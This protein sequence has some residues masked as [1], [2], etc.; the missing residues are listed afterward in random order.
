MCRLNKNWSA[1]CTFCFYSFQGIG[2]FSKLYIDNTG[3]QK[4]LTVGEWSIWSAY[5]HQS[6]SIMIQST[7]Q[8]DWEYVRGNDWKIFKIS[9]NSFY[10][11]QDIIIMFYCI[12]EHITLSLFRKVWEIRFE[13]LMG[14]YE[15]LKKM[16]CNVYT[17]RFHRETKRNTQNVLTD[18]E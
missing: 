10:V 3:C 9:T 4:L 7:Y 1:F 15:R 8:N 14:K 13:Y 11:K 6:Y 2:L 5:L 16:Y 18:V 12:S 17:G